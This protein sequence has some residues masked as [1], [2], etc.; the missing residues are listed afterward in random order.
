MEKQM[1]KMRP[2][3]LTTLSIDELGER[4]AAIA[5]DIQFAMTRDV[6]KRQEDGSG[7][8]HLRGFIHALN[9]AGG[10]TFLHFIAVG[11]FLWRTYIVSENNSFEN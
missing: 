6:Y 1:E 3:G 5:Q 7:Q 4:A 10:I 11:L 8:A 9:F 2:I